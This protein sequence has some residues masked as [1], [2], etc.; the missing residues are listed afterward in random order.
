[1][2]VHCVHTIHSCCQLSV[3]PIFDDLDDWEVITGCHL[4]R[5]SVPQLVRTLVSLSWLA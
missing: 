2:D 4:N 3:F 5:T 1:M